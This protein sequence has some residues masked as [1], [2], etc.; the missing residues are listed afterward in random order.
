MVVILVSFRQVLAWYKMQPLN[1][2]NC[3]NCY[4]LVVP[5]TSI[6]GLVAQAKAW[7]A[8]PNRTVLD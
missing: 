5:L 1:I 3:Q 8:R 2:N 6:W 4:G 7:P